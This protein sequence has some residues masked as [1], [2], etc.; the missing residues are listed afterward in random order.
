MPTITTTKWR[1]TSPPAPIQHEYLLL[2]HYWRVP[3]SPDP[4]RSTLYCPDRLAQRLENE[5]LLKN[6]IAALGR[7]SIDLIAESITEH[8]SELYLAVIN[9]CYSGDLHQYMWRHGLE[10]LIED[11]DAVSASI[12]KCVHG[13]HSVTKGVDI[14]TVQG[15]VRRCGFESVSRSPYAVVKFIRRQCSQLDV[16]GEHA[17]PCSMWL[18]RYICDLH[19]Q[20]IITM[21]INTFR[22]FMVGSQV[23]MWAVLQLSRHY[24]HLC[25]GGPWLMSD[26]LLFMSHSGRFMVTSGLCRLL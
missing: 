20:D 14:R 23:D 12:M 1:S 6:M 10:Y 9:S 5:L 8:S 26:L 4:N 19:A 16:V 7:M 11:T 2:D 25:S 21:I 24:P 15:Y 3:V 22:L 18:V 13:S 17:V